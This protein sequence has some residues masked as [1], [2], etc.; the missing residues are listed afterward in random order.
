MTGTT[1]YVTKNKATSVN[2]FTDWE[3]HGSRP[4]TFNTS[5]TPGQAFTDEWGIGQVLPLKKNLSQL[6]QIGVVGYDQ[7]QITA[8]GG[9]VPIGSTGLT[10]PA[11]LL[12]YYTVHAIG[13]QLNYIAPAKSLTLYFKGYDEYEAFNHFQGNTYVFGGAWT[14]GPR[15]SPPKS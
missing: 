1:F 12:P 13:G 4:G 7:W 14:F 6:L 2:L 11:S 10:A 8:N 5:K 15:K 9:M 3:D